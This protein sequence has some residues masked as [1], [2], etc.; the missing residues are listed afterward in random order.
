VSSAPRPTPGICLKTDVGPCLRPYIRGMTWP[1]TARAALVV[2]VVLLFASVQVQIWSS[3]DPQRLLHAAAAA[4]YT[5]PLLVAR[6]RPLEVAL[7]VVGAAFAD[8]WLDGH[9][10]QAWFAILLAVYALGRYADT[11]AAAIGM[12]AV[13]V[14]VLS[15]DLPRLQEGAPLD[16]VLPGWFVLGGVWGLG[17]WIRWRH[18]ETEAL[19]ARAAL[20]ERDREEAAR[21]AV[22][23]ERARIARELHDLVAHGLAVTVLQAQ[24]AQRVLA[25]DPAEAGKSLASIENLGRQG[26]SELRRLLEILDER[27]ATSPLDPPPTLSRLDDLVAQVREAGLPV[28]L[29]VSGSHA[30]VPSGVDLSAYRIVQESLTNVLKH[31][32]RGAT[33]DLSLTYRPDALEIVIADDGCGT[34][35]LPGTGR[36]LIGMRERVGLYGGSLEAGRR[37]EGGFVVRVLMPWGPAVA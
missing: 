35:V 10:G 22:A 12:A 21:A 1:R 32:G 25:Q 5:L 37:Q 7:I 18:G 2:L 28:T 30:D 36:G 11:R 29:T 26:L 15:V 27:G 19:R 33:V 16:E 4:A 23:H 9:G 8:H 17:R 31:A 6:R 3:G 34:A 14:G 24:A 13:G 20:L